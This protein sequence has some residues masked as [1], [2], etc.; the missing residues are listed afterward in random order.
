MN[1]KVTFS[2]RVQGVGFRYRA[3][4]CALEL[5]LLGTVR[6]C[7]DGSVE[8]YLQG[9][10]HAIQSLID[11]LKTHFKAS[12]DLQQLADSHSFSDFRIIR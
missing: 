10:R 3:Q 2:G 7:P 5:G 6:N 11:K 1:V 12:I 4:E 8:L 9:S